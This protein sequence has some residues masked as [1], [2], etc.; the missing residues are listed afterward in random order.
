MNV[1]GIPAEYDPMHTGH[2]HHLREARAASRADFVVAVMS[3]DFTQRGEPAFL[4]KWTRSRIAVENGADLVLELPFAYACGSAEY[5][6]FGAMTILRRLGVVT[7][8]ACGAE[9]P[10]LE[11]LR[12]IAGLMKAEAEEGEIQKAE[13]SGAGRTDGALTEG[14]RGVADSEK[15]RVYRTALRRELAAGRSFAAARG[16]A[17]AECLGPAAR[18]AAAAPNN[19]LAI[20]YLKFAGDL[21]PVLIG[22]TAPHHAA[23]A[24]SACAIPESAGAIRRGVF[25]CADSS[26]DPAPF[27][28]NAPLPD[29]TRAAVL[30]AF[31]SGQ[32]GHKE[33]FFDL[34]MGRLLT[35]RAD[36]LAGIFGIT[37]GMENRILA[38]RRKAGSV[39]ELI[40]TVRTKRYPYTTVSRMLIHA[41]VGFENADIKSAPFTDQLYGR[42][43]AVSK[44]GRQLLRLLR[45]DPLC[46]LPLV[47]GITREQ[48]TENANRL[49]GLDIR[50]A[51]LYNRGTGRDLYKE[52]DYVRHPY[53]EP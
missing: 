30:D 16:T 32:I 34:L 50:A 40:E 26:L 53:F 14:E 28:Q 11:L 36:E 9:T 31:H 27:L 20:E 13:G 38:A 21:T 18:S 39:G 7:H 25:Q 1:V 33:R 51:D 49:L 22:R 3:G 35:M 44:P 47:T 23:G 46:T 6:G 29:N 24:Q 2:I 48:E 45:D 19:I 37:E 41:L 12:E 43:L 4:D 5:F 10:D 15:V 8:V 42:V 17:I 52:S